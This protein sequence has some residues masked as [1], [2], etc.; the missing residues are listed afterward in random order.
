M[1]KTSCIEFIYS[2]DIVN[3]AKVYDNMEARFNERARRFS[4]RKVKPTYVII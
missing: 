4:D 2:Y 1:T 3:C